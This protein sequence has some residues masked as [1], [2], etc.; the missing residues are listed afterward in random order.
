MTTNR[1]SLDADTASALAQPH[2]IWFPLVQADFDSGTVRFAGAPFDIDYGGHTWL[3]SRGLLAIEP[4][5]EAPDEATGIRFTLSGV[6][7]DNLNV[8][9]TEPTQGRACTVLWCVVDGETLR[10][11]P[12]AWKGRLDVPEVQRTGEGRTVSITAEDPMADWQRPRVRFFN[13]ADQQRVDPA[14]MFFVGL[15]S[16]EGKSIVIFSKEVQQK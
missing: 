13:H 2:V 11:D 16:M 12:L 10:V 7:T 14:D 6:S 5:K 3:S 9:L 15:E 1:S 8:A 4:I